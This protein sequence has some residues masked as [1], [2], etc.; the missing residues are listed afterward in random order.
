MKI[1]V[2]QLKPGDFISSAKLTVIDVQNVGP[3]FIVDF[4][5]KTATA[6]IPGNI[7]VEIERPQHSN[8]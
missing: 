2:S 6:P 3:L 4:A 8:Q 7:P 1:T 5:D